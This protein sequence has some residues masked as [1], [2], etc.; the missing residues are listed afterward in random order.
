MPATHNEAP[1]AWVDPETDNV[2]FEV[3]LADGAQES[4]QPVRPVKF[5][6][7]SATAVPVQLTVAVTETVLRTMLVDDS[8]S[9][10]TRLYSGGRVSVA[11]TRL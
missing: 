6:V 7:T 3:A 2:Q 9:P 11:L 4:S 10:T 8:D 5:G 1:A